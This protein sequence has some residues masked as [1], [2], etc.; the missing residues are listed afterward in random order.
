MGAGA[1]ADFLTLRD[2][3]MLVGFW[4]NFPRR[5]GQ[6]AVCPQRWLELRS[7]IRHDDARNHVL[8]MDALLLGTQV[9]STYPFED[10]RPLEAH[11]PEGHPCLE[12]DDPIHDCA[13]Y[14]RLALGAA[15]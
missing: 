9:T 5:A 14:Y 3:D 11:M 13:C 10:P 8:E 4:S 15:P 2:A 7:H 6:G 12:A 1:V